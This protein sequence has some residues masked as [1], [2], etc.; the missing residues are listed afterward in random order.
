[1]VDS[2]SKY[3][4]AAALFEKRTLA[5][6]NTFMNVFSTSASL[7][8]FIQTMVE[9]FAIP[10]NQIYAMNIILGMLKVEK[11]VHGFKPR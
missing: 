11:D 10:V 7:L 8:Y 3:F 2:F 5:V 4:W 9:N 1:M 6:S